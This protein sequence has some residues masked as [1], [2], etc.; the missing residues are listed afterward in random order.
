MLQLFLKI[1]K[2]YYEEKTT[3]KAIINTMWG[4]GNNN[5]NNHD[6]NNNHNNNDNNNN[7][8]KS[9]NN[10]N[11]GFIIVKKYVLIHETV[12]N[13]TVTLSFTKCSLGI[14]I[15]NKNKNYYNINKFI[16]NANTN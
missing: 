15:N 11:Y 2:I 10:D 7:N 1:K 3:C 5:N 14:S 16:E 12:K 9:N 4:T 6:N 13:I 8:K